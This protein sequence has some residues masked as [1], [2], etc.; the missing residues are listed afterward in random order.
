MGTTF[1]V[2]LYAPDDTT[3]ARGRDGAFTTVAD[4]D[5]RLTDYRD[6]S[7]LMRACAEAWRHPGGAQPR[8]LRRARAWSRIRGTLGRS[9]R[10]DRR[11]TLEVVAACASSGRVAGRQGIG[12]R[13]ERRRLPPHDTRRVRA[14][15]ASRAPGSAPR[16]GRH[17]QGLRCG[18]GTAGAS[19]ERHPARDGR[20]RRRYRGR[21]RS[22]GRAGL[23]HRHR[24]VRWRVTAGSGR[25]A[26][27]RRHFDLRR[28]GAVH[29]ARRCPLL[30]RTRPADGEAAHR[31]LRRDHHRERRNHLGRHGQGGGRAGARRRDPARRRL[32]RRS[33]AHGVRDSRATRSAGW[34]HLIGAYIDAASSYWI[35]LATRPKSRF[36][37]SRS[38]CSTN[39]RRCRLETL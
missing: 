14:H 2:V 3:A 36:A 6:D 39:R 35:L 38:R 8:R 23:A 9:V 12:R 7:E 32:V 4:L 34:P 16:S 13:A 31:T 28:C 11:R 17:R 5:N 19:R 20:R 33:G 29:G 27:Q 30:A 22:A 25:H 15:A 24:A 10:H 37:I 26:G 1:R 21:R 18:S